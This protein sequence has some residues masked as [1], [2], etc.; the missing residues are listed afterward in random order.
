MTDQIKP[1]KMVPPKK[2]PFR[3]LKII[4]LF[5]V[6]LILSPILFALRYIEM[7]KFKQRH[8]YCSDPEC[9]GEMENFGFG[10]VCSKCGRR[11]NQKKI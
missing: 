6:A 2:D 9:V 7:Y 8:K 5:I 4:G 1:P 3:F 10:W 11:K